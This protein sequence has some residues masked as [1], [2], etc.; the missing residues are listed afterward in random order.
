MLVPLNKPIVRF[1]PYVFMLVP[2]VLRRVLGGRRFFIHVTLA[3]KVFWGGRWRELGAL[4]DGPAEVGDGPRPS[5]RPSR[6]WRSPRRWRRPPGSLH[7]TVGNVGAGSVEL[8]SDTAYREYIYVKSYT[9][10][11]FNSGAFFAGNDLD[12]P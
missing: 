4:A 9:Q 11:N 3:V 7:T 6:L 1:D 12:R 10:A 8:L 2:Y 5:T